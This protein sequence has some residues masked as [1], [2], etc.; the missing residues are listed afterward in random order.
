MPLPNPGCYVMADAGQPAGPGL[1]PGGAPRARGPACWRSC[2]GAGGR[3]GDISAGSVYMLALGLR[4]LLAAICKATTNEPNHRDHRAYR[5]RTETSYPDIA[6]HLTRCPVLKAHDCPFTAAGP[7][8]AAGGR[9]WR[10]RAAH[11]AGL[12]CLPSARIWACL[13]GRPDAALWRRDSGRAGRTGWAAPGRSCKRQEEPGSLNAWLRL[14]ID[15]CGADGSAEREDNLYYYVQKYLWN[16]RR[17]WKSISKESSPQP[18][19]RGVCLKPC[20]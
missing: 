16:C 2:P 15:A 19:R 8:V 13:I 5:R 6:G 20:P 9:L 11:R 3:I 1:A 18:K 14:E 12:D 7:L 17:H 4:L 10:V